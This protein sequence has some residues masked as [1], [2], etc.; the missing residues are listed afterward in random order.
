SRY[1][2]GRARSRSR[3]RDPLAGGAAD[4][5][6]I[7]G[8]TMPLVARVDVLRAAA[9]DGAEPGG[10]KVLVNAVS[11]KLGGAATYVRNLVRSL[12]TLAEP[13]DRFV[14]VVPP[15]RAGELAQDGERVRVL[16]GQP[17]RGS[18]ARGGGGNRG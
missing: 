13:E 12:E 9:V 8:G 15:E 10:M 11:A 16:E 18:N 6:R 17:R 4:L 1:G 3:I 2:I 5:V 14:F 7:P